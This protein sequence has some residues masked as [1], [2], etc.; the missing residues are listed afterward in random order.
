M[1]ILILFTFVFVHFVDFIGAQGSYG[2]PNLGDFYYYDTLRC[3]DH[4]IQYQQSCYRFIKSPLRGYNESRHICRAFSSESDLL[5]INSYDEHGFIIN[6]LNKQDSLRGRWYFGAYQQNPDMWRNAD[7]SPLVDMEN[8][9][10][11]VRK[12]YGDDYLVY[13]FSTSEM[14][15]GFVPVRGDE[16]LK[17]ICEANLFSLQRL[18]GDNRTYTYGIE[19]KDP[20]KIPRGPF[21]I[22]Q[23]KDVIFDVSRRQ[24]LNQIVLSCLAGGYPTPTYQ[25]FKEEYENDRLAAKQV[26][27]LTDDRYTLSGGMLIIMKPEEKLDRANY[28]CKASNKYGTIIS[29]SIALNFGYIHEFVLK[30]AAE[31]GDH[32]WG[33]VMGCDPPKF[34]GKVRYL[35]SREYFPNLVE[36][37]ER[38]FVSRDGGLYFSSLET[39][40]RGVYGCS[41][42]ALYS[43]TGKNGPFFQLKVNP[44]SSYEQ[45]KFAN[46]FP[47]IFTNP[48]KAG[49]EVRLECMAFGYPVPSYNWTRRGAPLPRNTTFQSYNRVMIIPKVT[50]EDQGEYVCTIYN[51]LSSKEQ[52][53]QLNVQAE[54]EFRIPLQDKHVDKLGQLVWLCEAF[55]I[56]DVNYTW[57]KNG[58]QLIKGYL[59]SEDYGRIIIQDNVLTIREVD[60][61]RDP[62]MYQCRASNALKARY[63]SAQLRVLS[64]KPSFKKRP[65][66][67]ETYAAEQGNVTIVCQPEAAPKPQFT[68]KKDGNIIGSGGHRKIMENGNLFIGPVSRNDEGIYTCSA[69]NE[70]GLDESRGRLIVL[71]GPRWIQSLPPRIV[72]FV[73]NSFELYCEAYIEELLDIAYIW[74]HNGLRIRNIDVKN[75]NNQIR[76]DGGHLVI[77]NATFADEGEYECLVTSSLGQIS[78]RS[79]VKIEG[80]PGPPGGVEAQIVNNTHINLLWTDGAAHGR[81]IYQYSVAG[82]TQWNMTWVNLASGIYA[83]PVPPNRKRALVQVSLTP[84]SIYEFRMTAS[85]EL[86]TGVPSSPSPRKSTAVDKPYLPPA[87]VG[88]GGGKRGDLTVTWTPLRN[89]QQNAPGIYYKIF[90]KQRLHETEFQTLSLQKQGNIG[91]AV[92]H[93]KSDHYY[94]EYIVKVQSINSEGEG[95]ISNEEVIYS[96]EDMPI[97]AP[98]LVK[99]MSYNS[100]ALNVSWNPVEQIRDRIRGKLIGHRIKY[101]RDGN[102]EQD[103][104][105]Y[106]SRTTRPWALIVGLVPNTYYNVKVMVYNGAGEGPESER[107]KE[108]TYKKPP[109]KPPSSVNITPI[110]PSTIKVIWRYVQPA[111]DEEPLQGFKVR[112]WENDQDISTA[113]DTVIPIGGELVAIIDGLVPGK[114]YKTRVLAYSNGGDGRMS[115][116][117]WQFRMGDPEMYRSGSKTLNGFSTISTVALCSIIHAILRRID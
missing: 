8:A 56:P 93:I 98:Q 83:Q 91:K 35:W 42:N 107:F 67:P 60:E 61:F 86:G 113:N 54:P 117:E 105:Y 30:R 44:Q 39:I 23:P 115:S 24:V 48:P 33:K 114:D 57:W 53:V 58:R 38:V 102:N 11:P 47:K 6:E 51:D 26:D 41:V 89:D 106:L 77:L 9:F 108:R 34:F 103:S 15:W 75:S 79:I 64:F 63:S 71:L 80:P 52:G 45:L 37:D 88:G 14:H 16:P 111:N 99:A 95:P 96:A 84:W 85:N 18:L 32:N 76:I 59:E 20:K 72:T 62:G 68:W 116:P 101:W 46:T 112:V 4:W 78:S 12:N 87:N 104:V 82:R 10:F 109:Q 55:G 49:E 50:V 94:T 70:N 21:F 1:W 27:P 66:E 73:H 2:P 90:F 22:Q 13:N 31:Q 100:T 5:S 74:H 69:Q 92:I 36:E 110:N 81:Q 43:D 17:F 40:D 29:E 7:D 25:W 28:H 3:P 65:L 97:V 19:I